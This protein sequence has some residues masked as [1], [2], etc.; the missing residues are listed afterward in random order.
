MV[1][2]VLLG[3]VVG[4]D[5][6]VPLK[7]IVGDGMI[8]LVRKWVGHV[9]LPFVVFLERSGWPGTLLLS[10]PWYGVGS[11]YGLKCPSHVFLL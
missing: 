7:V 1:D 6:G 3:M 11:P 4:V 5:W 8:K 2:D 10:I 9:R